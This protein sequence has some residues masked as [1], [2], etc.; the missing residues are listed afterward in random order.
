M[1][2]FAVGGLGINGVGVLWLY[3]DYVDWCSLPAAETTDFPGEFGGGFGP[4][5]GGCS[6]CAKSGE[7]VGA[8]DLFDIVGDRVGNCIVAAAIAV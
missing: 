6:G 2:R 3:F 7:S 5:I 4:G 8:G 1:G